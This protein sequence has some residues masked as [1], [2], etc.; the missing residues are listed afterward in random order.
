MCY[1][2]TISY[3]VGD[4][5]LIG[6]KTREVGVPMFS[7]K[8]PGCKK[9]DQVK[10]ASMFLA[11]GLILNVLGCADEP[12]KSPLTKTVIAEG[13]GT[14]PE[15]ALADDPSKIPSTQTVI[16]A[17]VGINARIYSTS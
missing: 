10:I 5:K 3:L 13:L 7:K 4:N 9:K 1:A 6:L 17:G 11:M 15:E 12:S 8:Y 14:I 2:P 16:A